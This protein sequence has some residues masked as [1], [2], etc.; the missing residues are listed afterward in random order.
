[1]III[2]YPTL[3]LSDFNAQPQTT[4]L[5]CPNATHGIRHK[6]RRGLLVGTCGA[7]C[8]GSLDHK[9]SI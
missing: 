7:L 3:I 8:A 9:G 2:L 4:A 1:M 6:R 5:T